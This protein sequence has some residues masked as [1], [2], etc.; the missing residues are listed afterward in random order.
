M[1]DKIGLKA[2]LDTGAPSNKRT[3]VLIGDSLTR[4][5]NLTDIRAPAN[6]QWMTAQIVMGQK[7]HVLNYGAVGGE[8]LAQ[9]AAKYDANVTAY[10]P[11]YVVMVL[12]GGNTLAAADVTDGKIV[13]DAA[14][15]HTKG[16]MDKALAGGSIFIITP[17]PPS[18]SYDTQAKINARTIYNGYVADFCQNKAGIIYIDPASKHMLDTAGYPA[19]EAALTSDGTHLS[20]EG[21]ITIGKELGDLLSA[22]LPVFNPFTEHRLE[23]PGCI[24][25][26]MYGTAG[27]SSIGNAPDSWP[28]SKSAA[29]TGTSVKVARSDN[30]P[31]EWAQLTCTN[32]T[33]QHE[34]IRY[35]QSTAIDLDDAGLVVGDTVQ[36]FVEFE[37]DDNPT[38][39]K[40]IEAGFRIVDP[41]GGDVDLILN[42][43]P[44][45]D[46][47]V[48]GNGGY[49][50]MASIPYTIP[51]DATGVYITGLTAQAE[52]AGAAFVVRYGRCAIRK[53]SS[54]APAIN[55]T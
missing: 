25:P 45:T 42:F 26:I 2:G 6:A 38:N 41:V 30:L 33:A 37:Y 4:V 47:A 19:W 24:N 5:V 22:Q 9:I 13:A 31:G 18:I 14:F 40:S 52:A 48:V 35:T 46:T 12:A 29:L 28:T 3:A 15:A 21:R 50:V 51:T 39:L 7:L 43:T 32:S 8:T 54:V 17:A 36:C 27:T 44:T 23:R 49:G 53:V 20:P 11:G 16:M 10:N 1:H 34:F 55:Q